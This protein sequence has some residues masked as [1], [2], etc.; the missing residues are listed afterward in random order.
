MSTKFL[1]V[2]YPYTIDAYSVIKMLHDNFPQEEHTFLIMATKRWV[3]ENK[4]RLLAFINLQYIAETNKY[5]LSKLRRFTE[6][7]C[8]MQEAEHIVL[9]SCYGITGKLLLPAFYFKKFARKTIW[10]EYWL[11]LSVGRSPA[12]KLIDKVNN[13]F[14]RKILRDIRFVGMP[15]PTD[16]D[17]YRTCT[18]GNAQCFFTPIPVRS[19]YQRDAHLAG[20]QR[21]CPNKTTVVLAGDGNLPLNKHREIFEA[22]QHF[23]CCN[24]AVIAFLDFVMYGENG[25]TASAQYKRF[26]HKHGKINLGSKYVTISFKNVKISK[27][28]EMLS[29]IDIMVFKGERPANLQLVFLLLYMGKKVFLPGDS[30]LFKYLTQQGIAVYDA[31]AIID[32][33]CEEFT[34]RI[35]PRETFE[36]LQDMLDDKAAAVHWNKLFKAIEHQRT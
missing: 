36:G 15:L 34:Q 24:I 5:P 29:K 33:N 20:L 11:D 21:S 31:N 30:G 13:G 27:Y 10:I 35:E 17:A 14:M 1:H 4:P 6:T 3:I 22:M 32:M 2:I 26:V 23:A 12:K 25:M 9:H 19:D 18:D 28:F 7:I 8:Y 16:E